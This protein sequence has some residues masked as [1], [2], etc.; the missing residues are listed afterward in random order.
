MTQQIAWFVDLCFFCGT[1]HPLGGC[2]KLPGIGFPGVVF[3]RPALSFSMNIFE[4]YPCRREDGSHK[5]SLWN[6]FYLYGGLFVWIL[7]K[8]RFL[9]YRNYSMGIPE[10]FEWRVDACDSL[11]SLNHPSTHPSFTHPKI[12]YFV[13]TK[14]T[15]SYWV[16]KI[17]E[18][19]KAYCICLC[20]FVFICLIFSPLNETLDF[21][22]NPSIFV[23]GISESSW[24][25]RPFSSV[26]LSAFSISYKIC[27]GNHFISI[28]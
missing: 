24:F 9:Q 4:S 7:W 10:L 5:S 25:R 18:C 1:E 8:R 6:H 13:C 27:Q 15:L 19:K 14:H 21:S 3:L 20:F 26:K 28:S 12:W 17:L 2:C 11:H 22:Y 16:G 23:K